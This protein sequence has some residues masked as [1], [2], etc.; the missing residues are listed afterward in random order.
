[1]KS[2]FIFI[3]FIYLT[4]GKLT[5]SN[6]CENCTGKI[7]TKEQLELVKQPLIIDKTKICLNEKY[8]FMIIVKSGNFQRRTLTRSTWAKEMIENFN[9]PVLYAIGYPKNSSIQ[10]EILVENQMYNDLLEF[11]ILDSYYNL[12]LKTSSVLFW[13]SQYCSTSSNYLLY[14]DDDVLIHVDKFITY[15]NEFNMTNTIV[16][17]FEKSG[18]IQR[19]GFGGATK[20]DFPIDDVPDYL[21]G[22]AVLYPTDLI[23]NFLLKF[24]F[25]TTLPIFFR[26][27]VFINGFIAEQAGIKRQCMKGILSYDPTEDDLKTHMIIIDFKTEENREKAW[28]CYKYNIQ[29]NKNLL[30][31]LIKIFS[32]VFLIFISLFFCC[33]LLKRTSYYQQLYYEFNLLYYGMAY[34]YKNNLKSGPLMNR[35]ERTTYRIQ[36]GIQ[37]LINLRRMGT[38][39]IFIFVL[40]FLIILIFIIKKI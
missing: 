5:T 40:I 22:A 25:N 6:I 27:D 30:L 8:K 23:S 21:W 9:I 19:T 35:Q 2:I 26:D 31:L 18:K 14:V 11:N 36:L 10:K 13:Y 38:K 29:C 32:G 16:G 4:D 1:M 3:S 34:P 24:L 33:K 12:T 7:H 15:M 28:N 37:W 20:E 39:I 17:W